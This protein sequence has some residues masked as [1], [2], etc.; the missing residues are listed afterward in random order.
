M[1]YITDSSVKGQARFLPVSS[2]TGNI[3]YTTG[4]STRCPLA[5][6]HQLPAC[7]RR[8]P[9]SCRSS[10]SSSLRL[11]SVYWSSKAFEK[12]SSREKKVS[13]VTIGP[14]ISQESIKPLSSREPCGSISKTVVLCRHLETEEPGQ[15]RC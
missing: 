13:A 15:G 4:K 7:Q 5:C 9:I 11:R 12:R 2:L 14:S 8:Q 10:R 6:P 3:C 1:L